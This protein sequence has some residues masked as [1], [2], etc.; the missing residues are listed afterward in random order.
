MKCYMVYITTGSTNEAKDI[1]GV[2]IREKFA[3]CANILPQMESVYEWEG[4]ICNDKEAVLILKTTQD[5]LTD[6]TDCVNELHS[7]DLPCIVA[8]P[9]EN[10]SQDFLKWIYNEIHPPKE[11]K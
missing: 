2:V 7:Y 9:I 3:A 11:K 1:A 5:K 10:G 6:L 8:L 4:K